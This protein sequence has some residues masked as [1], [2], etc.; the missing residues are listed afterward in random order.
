MQRKTLT[1]IALA[2]LVLWL[3]LQIFHVYLPGVLDYLTTYFAAEQQALYALATLAMVLL[4]PLVYR[5]LGE[6]WLLI[7]TVTGTAVIRLA[8]QFTDS[9][10]LQLALSTLGVILWIWFIPFWHQSRLNR[11]DSGRLAGLV[12]AFPLAIFLDTATRALIWFDEIAWQDGVLRIL[13]TVVLAGFT[14]WLLWQEVKVSSV[15]LSVNN[16]SEE[17]GLARLWPFVGVGPVLYL[18]LIIF[19]NP[20][21][22]VPLLAGVD[23]RWVYLFILG[24]A[25]FGVFEAI[26]ANTFFYHRRWLISLLLGGTLVLSLLLYNAGIDPGW[27]WFGFAGIT[28][29]ALF[30]ILLN[31]TSRQG[32]L[33]KGLWR[34]GLVTFLALLLMLLIFFM[35]DEF[36]LLFMNVVA[37]ILILL[38]VLWAAWKSDSVFS[39]APAVVQPLLGGVF[40]L[41]ALAFGLWAWA[42][43]PVSVDRTSLTSVF[44]NGADGYACYRI[45]SLVRAG[46]GSLVAIAEGRVENCSD[47]NG[48]I[49]IV[50]K[51]SVDNGRSWGQLKLIGNNIDAD[52]VE[53]I[54]Q[55]PTALVDLTDPNNPQGKLFLFF[56]KVDLE[57]SGLG[58]QRVGERRAFLAQSLD[59]G[60][61]W[62][63]PVD[64]TEQIMLA[65]EPDNWQH[66]VSAVGHAIQ[67]RGTA[68]NQSTADRLFVPAQANIDGITH[69][70]AFWSDDH[71]AT[72][73]VGGVNPQPWLNEVMAVEREDG[74]IITNSRNYDENQVRVGYRAVTHVDFDEQGQISFNEA[75]TDDNLQS[76]TVQAS[77]QRYS[78]PDDAQLGSKNRILFSIPDHGRLRINMTVRLSYDEGE[79]WPVAKVLDRGPSSYSD[80]VVDKEDMIGLL[81]ERGND[82]GIY[83]TSFSLDW[84][85]ENS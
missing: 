24:L 23:I 71:G 30:G 33:K 35:V 68:E 31:Q 40:V 7:V 54:A 55:S 48:V 42:N 9:E 51:R 65:G 18:Q 15:Q 5:L 60:V 59:H 21:K 78:W 1:S 62:S 57:R 39:P 41:V 70:Y 44:S 73:E 50:A 46:D 77:I 32:P 56:N 27:L 22:L 53:H 13:F 14:L 52:G 17:P 36:S 64:V 38:A 4:L 82:G 19:T 16:G 10:A 85:E 6:K 61:T 84:L 76:P 80:L 72:W 37:G 28:T 58:A 12:I 3:G 79:S 83:Y 49:R 2:T 75:Y 74:G 29:W 43:Q 81:Y 34:D 63:E 25:A 8:I 11:P 66:Q 45:P 47:G 20:A 26:E 67:L 69:N